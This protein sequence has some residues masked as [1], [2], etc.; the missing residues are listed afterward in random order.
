[1]GRRYIAFHSKLLI[2]LILRLWVRGYLLMFCYCS[3]LFRM[4]IH[5]IT[6]RSSLPDSWH[7][8][9]MQQHCIMV[10]KLI[11][12]RSSSCTFG[13]L[14]ASLKFIE[15]VNCSYFPTLY[16]SHFEISSCSHLHCYG[17]TYICLTYSTIIYSTRDCCRVCCSADS[18]VKR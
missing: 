3:H 17:Y 7:K 6:E 15:S 13:S 12:S 4:S 8:R 1:M 2:S 10:C 9:G 18:T 11:L 5:A 14:L 16:R